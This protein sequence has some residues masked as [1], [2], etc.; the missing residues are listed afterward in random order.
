VGHFQWVMLPRHTI[1]AEPDV[2]RNVAGRSPALDLVGRYVDHS[3][4]ARG[5]SDDWVAY[6]MS[7]SMR[8]RDELKFD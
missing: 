4:G 1:F 5:K 3:T 8:C 2:D 6:E 7:R